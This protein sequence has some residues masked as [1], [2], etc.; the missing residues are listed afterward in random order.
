MTP[1][2]VCI[3][4]TMLAACF[5]ARAIAAPEVTPSYHMLTTGNGFGFSVF[6]ADAK[7]LTTFLERPYRSLRAGADPKGEGVY[8]RDLAHEAYFG[9]RADGVGAWL[10]TL[11]QSEVGYVEQTGVIRSVSHLGSV[12]IESYYFA[13]YGLDANALVMI[14]H[15]T[16]RG[17]APTTVDLFA[18][19]DFR[20][21]EGGD[22]PSGAS[23]SIR[24]SG[25][26]SI[27]TGAL[28]DAGGAL[29]YL[30]LAAVARATCADDARDAVSHARALPNDERNCDGDDRALVFQS[31]PLRL[32]SGD[33]ADFGLIIGFSPTA[34][35]APAL[36]ATLRD[37]VAARSAPQLLDDA[38]AEWS[39]WRRSPPDGLSADE[40][41]VYRQAEAT[42]RM[43]QV[44]EP[45]APDHRSYGMLLA[46]LPPGIWHIGWVRDAT[47]AIVALAHSG[48]LDEARDALRFLLSAQAGRYASFVHGPYRISVTRYFGDGTEESDWNADGPN[49]EMDG[50]GLTLWALRQYLDAA[51]SGALLSEALPTN[52]RTFDVVRVL[53]GKALLDNQEASGLIGMDTS[54][55]ESHWQN[56]KHY[57]YTSLAA[58]RGLCDLAS[59]EERYGD[60]KG[61]AIL[62][63]RVARLRDGL[64]ARR[65][66]GRHVS[67]RCHARSVQLGDL[68][69]E[70]SALPGNAVR[71]RRDLAFTVGRLQAQRRQRLALRLERMDV[72]RSAHGER[73]TLAR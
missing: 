36:A 1:T 65:H 19:P 63:T 68:R 43:S 32:D 53:I 70:R 3:I 12:R 16:N 60:G 66:R 15:V 62:R 17:A 44:R 59:V 8:R 23:E 73:A 51:G 27:E 34:S 56:R 31:T 11:P 58:A 28:G 7:K 5:A 40:R 30:P 14:A 33:S 26:V 71:A 50:W 2:R 4:T 35:A 39:T 10:P 13:P 6:D 64:L 24:T 21:G 9:A 20:L 46:S 54:I 45:Y 18:L 48:H 29:V 42:L 25:D 55:W 41:R 67:R 61:A 69:R 49:V 72:H 37:F 38:L 57:A 52:E 22:D 47:Y